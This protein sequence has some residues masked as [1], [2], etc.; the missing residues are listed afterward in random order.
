MQHRSQGSYGHSFSNGA[1]RSR[2]SGSFGG[3]RPSFGGQRGGRKMRFFDPSNIIKNN[4]LRNE[5]PEPEVIFTPVHA[6]ADFD[7]HA[8]LHRNIGVR[9]YLAPTPIQDQAIPELLAGRDMIG[10]ANTGTG[11]TAAFLIPLINKVINDPTQGVLIVA[12]TRELAVQIEQELKLFSAGMPLGSVLCIGGVNI[13]PQMAKLRRDP[14]FVIGTPGR[15]KDLE[16]QGALHFSNYQNIV[17]D[18]VDQMFD[19]GFIR[20]V[21]HIIS[22]LP[23]VRHSLFFSATLPE[24][25][26]QIMSEFLTDPIKISVKSR[27][28]AANVDQ[29]VINLKGQN[30]MDALHE[31]LIKVEFEKVLVF[32]RTKHATEKLAQALYTRGFTV[33]AIHGNKSQGQRQR[34]IEQF[35]SNRVKILVATDVASRGLDIDNV[36]HVIN[37][38]LPESYDDYIHRIGRTG[39]ANRKGI[40]LT[41]ID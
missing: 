21:K 3:R 27:D 10:L 41:F 19:M 9:G 24:Q 2:S 11:K 8:D 17:L 14:H 30:K 13:R 25:L 38:D 23:K 26:Q 5:N 22:R 12:P 35:K 37:F 32:S 1:N 39:R 28:T 15:L 20:D 36:T 31:L 33:D 29:D 34:A 4:A 40:A 16:E 6:F 18:E 7:L